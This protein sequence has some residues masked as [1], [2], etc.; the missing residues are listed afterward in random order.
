MRISEAIRFGSVATAI[1]IAAPALAF[2]N[3]QT[4]AAAAAPIV[5]LAPTPEQGP[6]AA[7]PS[8]L[9]PFEAFRSG[10]QAYLAGEKGK[11]LSE[12][13]YAAEQGDLPAQW[14][15][16]RMYAE[17]DGV[18]R[19]DKKAFEYFNKLALGNADESPVG[20]HAR[21]VSSAFVAVGTYYLTGIP[22]SDVKPDRDRAYEML[23]YAASY[24]GDPDA[25][26]RLARLYLGAEPK[27]PRQAARW[28]GLA[29]Q[30]GQYKAQ[31]LLGHMLVTGEGGLPKQAARGL[32]WLTLAHEAMAG[33]D[34]GWISQYYNDAMAQTTEDE[35]ALAR[36]YVDQW[37]WGNRR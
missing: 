21:F 23:S 28:L 35:R 8:R 12:L 18:K 37:L 25:Q 31:A 20:P 32:M 26:Y 30:K 17:G 19:D 15:I 33:A 10:T 27:D 16:G 7:P 2:D 34:D 14:K 6:L 3:Q 36:V 9:T 24:F 29:A 22:N 5:P 13:R 1:L 11:A 4:P